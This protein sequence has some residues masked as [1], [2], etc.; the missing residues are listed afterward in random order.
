LGR[1]VGG[2]ESEYELQADEG[3]LSI[4]LLEF[5][6]HLFKGG[7]HAILG[8]GREFGVAGIRHNNNVIRG[9]RKGSTMARF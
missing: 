3:F 9:L 2:I 6:H 7:H 5:F 4:S 8:L 1:C